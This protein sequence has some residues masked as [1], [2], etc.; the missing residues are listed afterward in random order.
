MISFISFLMYLSFFILCL[1]IEI[2]RNKKWNNI[3]YP[4]SRLNSKGITTIYCI[5]FGYMT[6]FMIINLIIGVMYWYHFKCFD[7]VINCSLFF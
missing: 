5:S 6:F 4:K 3:F 1:G 2:K 7:N